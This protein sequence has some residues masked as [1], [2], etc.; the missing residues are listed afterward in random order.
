MVYLPE[1]QNLHKPKSIAKSIK[2]EPKN[3][4]SSAMRKN[5]FDD[6]GISETEAM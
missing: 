3:K 4:N 5:R 1:G 2:S 6:F